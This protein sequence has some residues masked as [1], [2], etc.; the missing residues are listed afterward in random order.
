MQS[1]RTL[2]SSR[3][4]GGAGGIMNSINKTQLSSGLDS[5]TDHSSSLGLKSSDK[6]VKNPSFK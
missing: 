6:K 4:G 1:S 2:N 3:S 5:P